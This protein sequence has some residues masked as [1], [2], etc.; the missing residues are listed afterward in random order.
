MR[1]QAALLSI[2][3][4]FGLL[5]AADAQTPSTSAAGV[6]SDGTY[7]LVSSQRVNPLYTSDN[8]QMAQCPNRT[9]GPFHIVGNRVDYTSAT[10]YRLEGIVGSQ[11]GL[12]M[13][14]TN[15][16]GGAQ[17]A[18]LEARGGIDG[19]GTIRL[20]ELGSSCSYDFVWQKQS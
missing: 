2:V 12:R 10:G 5:G 17:P 8:G 15:M 4:F 19:N 18:R 11:G 16:V 20:R 6:S 13:R 3:G 1:S 7:L 14:A 9:P